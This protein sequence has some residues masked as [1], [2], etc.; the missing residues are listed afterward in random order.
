LRN[1]RLSIITPIVSLFE[2]AFALIY[3]GMDNALSINIMCQRQ[4]VPNVNINLCEIE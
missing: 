1:N 2:N 3:I 4:V